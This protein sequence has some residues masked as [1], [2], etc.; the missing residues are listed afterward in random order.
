MSALHRPPA[1]PAAA[2]M[3][4]KLNPLDARFGNLGLILRHHPG[5]LDPAAAMRAEPRQGHIHNLIDP[6][7]DRPPTGAAIRLSGFAP[8]LC[9]MGFGTSARERCRLP[10]RRSQRF[11]QGAPQTIVLSGQLLNL[12]FQAGDLFGVG[13]LRHV[14]A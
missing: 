10:L 6:L 12:A 7:R 3:N 8:G 1:T 4:P 13:F 11:F 14:P 2:Q 9:R 5:F